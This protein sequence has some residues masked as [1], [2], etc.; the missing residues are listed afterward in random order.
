[1]RAIVAEEVIEI[2][3]SCS[4]W[5]GINS[6]D[7]FKSKKYKKNILALP[8]S[9]VDFGQ[10][11]TISAACV[12][13]QLCVL[14]I[15]LVTSGKPEV[16]CFLNIA[17]FWGVEKKNIQFL[18][19]TSNFLLYRLSYCCITVG[20]RKTFISISFSYVMLAFFS[21][22]DKV[23]ELAYSTHQNKHRAHFY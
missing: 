7:N 1:M 2:L 17:F 22:F 12:A 19:Y 20:P 6:C 13:L 10:L 18:Q 8:Q 23:T 3:F 15:L 4:W 5:D 9:A 14:S 21:I 16:S 11:L